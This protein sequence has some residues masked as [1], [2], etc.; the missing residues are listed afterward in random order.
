M[1]SLQVI[2]VLT[3]LFLFGFA[4][5]LFG[6]IEPDTPTS[7]GAS[8]VMLLVGVSLFIMGFAFL[9]VL[10]S[11][12]I[13]IKKENRDY[14]SFNSKTWL[15]VLVINLTFLLIYSVIFITFSLTS[16]G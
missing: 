15:T 7:A 5:Y 14:F 12:V 1:K 3:P 2:G 16:M 9:F 10:P 8:L 6:N 4:Y 11:S 13:L